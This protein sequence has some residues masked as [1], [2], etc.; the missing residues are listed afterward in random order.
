M[1]AI[2]HGSG[3]DLQARMSGWVARCANSPALQVALRET[4]ATIAARRPWAALGV[5][6]LMVGLVGPFGTYEMLNLPARLAYWAAN[7]AAT[8]FAATFAITYAE[9]WL[10]QRVAFRPIVLVLSA[11]FAAIPVAAIVV[12]FGS[13][14]S[15]KGDGAD[16]AVLYG[17]CA[18]IVLGIAVLFELNDQRTITAND[19]DPPASILSRLPASKRGRLICLAA[20]DHYTEVVTTQGRELVLMR[21][22]DAIAETAPVDGIHVH[23][24]HWVASAAVTGYSRKSG[25]VFLNLENGTLAPVSRSRIK[26]AREAGLI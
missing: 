19:A 26:A 24:S 17:Y 11:L 15:V 3:R 14:A 2:R 8:F 12:A 1:T 7:V 21:L 22:T 6:S 20:Q 9:T 25:R 23:R 10:A 18:S 4:R 16:L 13:V 5:A